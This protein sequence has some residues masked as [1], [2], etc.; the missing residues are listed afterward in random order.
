[1]KKILKASLFTIMILLINVNPLIG[2]IKE[3]KSIK[4]IQLKSPIILDGIL[5]EP[6]YLNTPFDNFIQKD[7][8][9]GASASEKTQAWIFYDESNI[10]ICAKMLDS[11]PDSIDRT[12]M[13]RDN[14][15]D[16][17]WF[18]VY[19][20]PYNDNKTG[21]Y[22]SVNAGGSMCD[23][24][25]YNDTDMDNGW[26]GKWEAKINIDEDGWSTEIRIPFSQFRFNE[27]N[28]MIWGINLNRDIK[29]KHE[30]SFLV[31]VPKS[32]SGFVSRFSDLEGLKDIKLGNRFELLPYFVQK[33]QYLRNHEDDPFYKSTQYKTSIGA[34][35]KFGIGTNLNVDATINP[36]FGQVEVDPAIVNLSAFENY[37]SE[38][39]VFF[40]EGSKIFNFGIGGANNNWYFNFGDPY[41]FYSR[42]IGRNPQCLPVTEGKVSQPKETR[43]LGS[44]KLTGKI[45]ESWTIGAMSAFTERTYAR[46]MTPDLVEIKE[47]VE[48]FTHYGVLRTMK[49]FN[50]GKGALGMIF[51]S[52]N[53][54]LR[55][56]NLQN[57]LTDQSYVFG[58]DGWTFLDQNK[59][60]VLTSSIVGSYVHGT[61]E[62]LIRIQ[63]SP[64]RYF[65]RPDKTFMIL[66]SNLTSLAG[67][68]SRITL[69]KQEGNFY[70]NAAVGTAS[71]GFEYNDLGFQSAVDRINGHIVLGYRWFE[72]DETYRKKRVYFAVS[73]TSDYENNNLGTQIYSNGSLEFLNYCGLSMS[74]IYDFERVSN[75]QTRGGPRVIMP[76][77][78]QIGV[79]G[80]SDSRDKIIIKPGF[81]FWIDGL[82]SNRY[83]F[84][85]NVIWKPKSNVSFTFSPNYEY[86]N[87][88]TQWV[89]AFSDYNAL[90]TFGKR[91]VFSNMLQKTLSADFR[92]NWS[93]TPN[94]S[95][96]LFVQP[97][98]SV[99]NYQEFK[100][101]VTPNSKEYLTYGNSNTE[102]SYNKD[103]N[104]YTVNPNVNGNTEQFTFNNPNFNFKSIRANL[105]L[106][107][108]VKPGSIFYFVWTHDKINYSNNNY[109]D[110]GT[111][112]TN[113]WD[114]PPNNILLIKFSYW[115]DI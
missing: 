7:P 77:R 85:M 80:Y 104:L 99:G 51:T 89:G 102:I 108:E 76:E 61:N 55:Q 65:N 46:I 15:A 112:F 11:Q 81:N 3:T 74:A 23:G 97:V 96:Q 47:E 26:D 10:Y 9:E 111:D 20:D 58:I 30:T 63:K 5:N 25:L 59:V 114:S 54:D 66:D 42:R 105:V 87:S 67:I 21:Y 101:L 8:I 109:L 35:L 62:A 69:N 17:D 27:S 64:Y 79:S 14:L 57:L 82:N 33:A 93:F 45:D 53:R 78:F 48:P 98:F 95:L 22:F 68:Y 110:I 4:A 56:N 94:L 29:R 37:Y 6:A 38:K 115:F 49:E 18:W 36:D 39:R 90:R 70:L 107:W 1:M 106:R 24:I 2:E 16:S 13:R 44:S 84:Y 52:V 50:D 34:D 71:P 72:P 88:K 40:N 83:Y 86:Y 73:R 32:E 92:V 91:Y 103:E 100:E 12:L 60:Y 75:T 31:M 113:L 43:I 19:I 41:L 28:N